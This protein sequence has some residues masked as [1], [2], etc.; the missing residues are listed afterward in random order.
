MFLY[1]KT[2]GQVEKEIE[3]LN[4]DKFVIMHPG[5]IESKRPEFRFAEAVGSVLLRPLRAIS[6]RFSSTATEIA[7]AM[8]QATQT[9]DSGKLIWDN[10]KIVDE[11]KKYQA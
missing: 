8:I 2:K 1:W 9:A 5:L 11:A 6:S 10:V 4:F 3:Q 7:Q